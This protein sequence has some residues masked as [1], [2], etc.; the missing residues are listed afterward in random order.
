MRS[1]QE[2]CSPV[3]CRKI[4]DC[5]HL[6]AGNCNPQGRMEMPMHHFDRDSC[7]PAILSR[8][9]PAEEVAAAPEAELEVVPEEGRAAELVAAAV[10]AAPEGLAALAEPEERA[11]E[12]VGRGELVVREERAAARAVPT[13]EEREGEL[14][15]QTV[16]QLPVHR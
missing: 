14:V 16:V 7:L 11:A 6:L 1:M 12:L 10:R 3:R 15:A 13:V 9:D 2:D 5:G 8:K 4:L